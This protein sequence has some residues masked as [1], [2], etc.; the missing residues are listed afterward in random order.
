MDSATKRLLRRYAAKY[1]TAD[2]FQGGS[3]PSCFM[4]EVAAAKGDANREA[5]AFV[6]SAFSFGSI[7]QFVPKVR[8]IVQ[9]ASGDVDGWIRS[10]AFLRHVPPGGKSFYRFVT[11]SNLRSFLSAYRALM[12][13]HGTLGEYV[14]AHGDGTGLG[15]VKAIC[16][17][18][19]G[20]DS[21]YLV[22]VDAT[23]ACKRVCMFLR[24]MVRGPSPV[25]LGLWKGFIDRRT[26]VV[27][28]DTHVL[29]QAVE[30]GLATS[31]NASMHAALRLT[32]SLAEAFPDDPLKGD[33][34]LFGHGL[35]SSRRR[36]AH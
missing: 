8:G 36:A 31:R 2:F 23:S 30:L 29:A 19:R 32:E 26:L 20:S 9:L 16:A 3:D 7:G 33:F 25:D 1:E 14:R 28:L 21:G 35:F 10:G 12:N 24:W 22:P 17:A 11:Y 18:F 6:A 5:T 13:A 15:A 27:P 4:H 34:A